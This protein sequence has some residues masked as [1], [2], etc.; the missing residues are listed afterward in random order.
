MAARYCIGS[1]A[2]SPN[3]ARRGVSALHRARGHAAKLR[4]ALRKLRA[5][6]SVV[7]R[8]VQP[9]GCGLGL[10]FSLAVWVPQ[11]PRRSAYRRCSAA[12]ARRFLPPRV[13]FAAPPPARV[14][15]GANAPLPPLCGYSSCRSR[16]S[17]S[18]GSAR[19]P[20]PAPSPSVQ[21]GSGFPRALLPKGAGL[22]TRPCHRR[23]APRR[24]LFKHFFC[25]FWVSCACG[26]AG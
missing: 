8:L 14:K 17:G 21:S 10:R 26:R 3:L 12:C 23:N 4:F 5:K 22:S 19:P 18:C 7:L 13:W 25:P 9:L 2:D 15:P 1:F 20:L 16:K 24:P 6:Q 11:P